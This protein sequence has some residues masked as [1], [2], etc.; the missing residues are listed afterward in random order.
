MSNNMHVQQD[1]LIKTPLEL[2]SSFILLNFDFQRF[3]EIECVV[4]NRSIYASKVSKEASRKELK[5][6]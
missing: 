5:R 6:N 4:K 1:P 2:N 3:L